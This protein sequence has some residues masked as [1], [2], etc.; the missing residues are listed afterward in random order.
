MTS[1]LLLIAGMFCN[2]PEGTV[3][4]NFMN[5]LIKVSIYLA[6]YLRASCSSIITGRLGV[7]PYCAEHPVL[8]YHSWLKV[9]ILPRARVIV[10]LWFIYTIK[11][12][13]VTGSR[14]HLFKK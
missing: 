11:R 4:R 5:S 12:M 9:A 13:K 6:I 10:T 3:L 1:G 8:I 14:V 2:L 7:V